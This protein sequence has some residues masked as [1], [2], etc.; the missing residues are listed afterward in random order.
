M[1]GV[2][3]KSNKDIPV[4]MTL[5]N[6]LYYSL[7]DMKMSEQ[8]LTD[9]FTLNQLPTSYIK[10]ISAP[11][12]F[13]RASSS[14][15]NRVLFIK[16]SNCIDSI[17]IKLEVDEVKSDND[18]VTRIIGR[19][20]IDEDNKEVNY[21]QIAVI[22]YFRDTNS[23]SYHLKNLDVINNSVY[24]TLC[25]EIQDKFSEWSMYHTKDTI[26]NTILRIIND[27]H[28]IALTPTGL[29]KFVPRTH[30]DL[31]Y[32][33]K[34]ALKGMEQ[35]CQNPGEHNFMEVIP[36]INTEEQQG[37]IKDASE[38]ELTDELF[39][40]TQ[41]LKDVLQTRKTLGSRTVSSYLD[42]FKTIKEKVDDYEN[43]LGN[44]LGFLKMQITE[45]VELIRENEKQSEED[46]SICMS[47]LK[48]TK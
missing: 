4:D 22:E 10:K 21:E 20:V 14:I 43:L 31:L 32:S 33:L 19:K 48:E 17:K 28:P 7:S 41:E 44:Y 36:V 34:E 8:E 18:S 16:D 38:R 37:L 6:L 5:G 1:S 25:V 2:I 40:F 15:K 27:T 11:D 24:E 12:A 30:T 46:P 35:F 26:R 9:V 13:R 23:V 39:G 3:C 47:T 29:C 45:S 42:R